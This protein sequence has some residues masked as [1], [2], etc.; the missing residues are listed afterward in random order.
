MHRAI[1]RKTLVVTVCILSFIGCAKQFDIAAWELDA[2]APVVH[3]RLNLADLID[4]EEITAAGDGIIHVQVSDTLLRLGLD[5]LIGIPD[6]TLKS[7]FSVPVGGIQ[8][9]PGVPFY[10][11]TIRTRFNLK[12]VALTYAEVK[13]SLFTVDLKN[14]LKEPILVRYKI[15]SA[16]SNGDTFEL[17]ELVPNK[18]TFSG[19]YNLDGYALNLRGPDGTKVNMIYAYVEALIDPAITTNYTFSAGESFKIENTFEE[20]IPSYAK[21]FFGQQSTSYED[22][23]AIELFQSVAFKSAD[24]VDFDVTFTIDNGIG[25]DLNL[26]IHELTSYNATTAQSLEHSII[27]QQ[28]TF[29]RAIDLFNP[30]DPV[31]HV[32]KKISFTP[33]NSN[34]DALVEI[35]PDGIKY[36]IDLEVNPLGNVSLGNDFVYYGHDISAFMDMDIPLRVGFEGLQLSDTFDLSLDSAALDEERLQSGVLRGYITNG[37]PFSTAI[38]LFFLDS[39]GVVLD[40]LSET[41]QQVMAAE[42]DGFGNVSS[43]SE[44]VVEFPFTSDDVNVLKK[45]TQCIVKVRMDTYNTG[46]VNIRDD[47][48]IDFKFVADLSLLAQ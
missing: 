7:E 36:G 14:N 12:D 11:D 9:P 21:G 10:R 15:L 6:T 27:D 24:I 42:T 33:S 30:A 35:R 28:Q 25:A 45:T 3:G 1:T 38:Q 22:S 8:W 19:E 16:T 5:S 32:Q 37:Y 47:F 20:I 23:T 43:A 17:E 40:S 34:L 13:R 4:V 41:Q 31:K 44:S 39:N 46:V 26:T 48:Y 2:L 18:G 29:G